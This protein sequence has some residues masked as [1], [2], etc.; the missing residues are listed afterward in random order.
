MK[1]FILF[2]NRKNF[3]LPLEFQL[4]DNR[5][6]SNLVEHFL[7][8]YT[9]R[10]DRVI[11]IFAGFGTTLFVAEDLGRIPFGIEI[12]EKRYNY[13]RENLRDTGSVI[14][15]NALFLDSYDLPK[16]NFSIS[17][18]PY[19]EKHEKLNPLTLYSEE[20][21]YKEYLK[22]LVLIYKK[23]KKILIPGAYIV[24]EVSNLKESVVTTL[25]WD[26]GKE[27]SK[28]FHFHGEIIICWE[29]NETKEGT[30]GYGYDHS[31]CLIF[32]NKRE[33]RV[34]D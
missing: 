31:Y 4:D 25:A 19:M 15:G 14:L 16:I 1:T 12:D 10:G 5:Y 28:I 9:E 2:D 32:Q 20:G 24:I 11:D 29:G 8:M 17:S 33:E 18:P 21:N 7:N 13:I 6:T 3:E 27:I 30:Y 26:I 23:L 22:N 34:K